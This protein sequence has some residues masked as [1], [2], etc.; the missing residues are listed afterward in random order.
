MCCTDA[1]LQPH[2]T[3]DTVQQCSTLGEIS[4]LPEWN[5]ASQQ[6]LHALYQICVR[7]LIVRAKQLV[8][9]EQLA[10]ARG[11]QATAGSRVTFVCTCMLQCQAMQAATSAWP[12]TT[13]LKSTYAAAIAVEGEPKKDRHMLPCCC[14]LRRTTATVKGFCN[15]FDAR[16]TCAALLETKVLQ[17]H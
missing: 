10:P 15:A 9:P 4:T 6:P 12:D 13:T 7:M 11:H 17:A 5:T 2:A 16:C 3:C 1:M 14:S 8:W